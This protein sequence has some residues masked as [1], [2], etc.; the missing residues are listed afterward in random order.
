MASLLGADRPRAAWLA[1][2]RAGR[3][4]ASFPVRLADGVDGRQVEDV[5]AHVRDVGQA[6]LE[7]AERAVHTR[8]SRRARECLVP[9]AEPRALR[10]DHDLQL[11]LVSGAERAVGVPVHEGVKIFLLLGVGCFRLLADRGRQR[12]Q[13]GGV[14]TARAGC[15]LVDEARTDLDLDLD[16]LS[17]GDSLGQARR[18]RSVVVDPALDRVGVA[19]ELGDVEAAAPAVVDERR[20]RHLG[21]IRRRLVAVLEHGGERVV[22]VREDVGFDDHALADG[23]F[24]RKSAGVHLWRDGLDRGPAAGIG[25]LTWRRRRGGGRG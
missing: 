22:A 25:Q 17:R 6:V 4:V 16:V 3:V 7:V 15:R 5:E 13:L 18:P 2:L 9:G 19:A 11:A 23:P 24:D 8:L 14:L 21:P 20:H 10:L 1:R 12:G